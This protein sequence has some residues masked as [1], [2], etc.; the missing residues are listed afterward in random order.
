VARDHH[1]VGLGRDLGG[2]PPQRTTNRLLN[3]RN[4]TLDSVD[5]LAK[6][7]GVQ[8][9]QLFVPNMNITAAVLENAKGQQITADQERL[10]KAYDSAPKHIKHGV[11]AL[12]F[13][14]SG[15][16]RSIKKGD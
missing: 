3:G 12:L 1:V 10:I 11:D 16:K 5:K 15:K 14:S 9:W 6:F 4:A 7:Y 2:G 8:A 13:D